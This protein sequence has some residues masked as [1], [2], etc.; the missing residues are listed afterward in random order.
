MKHH[1]RAA[2]HP[3]SA[4]LSI[5]GAGL[6]ARNIELHVFLIDPFV[7]VHAILLRI[8]IHGVVPPVEQGIG[9]RPVDRIAVAA[10]GII[11]DQPA[12]DVIDFPS[13]I[14]RIQH[15]EEPSLVIVVFI[16]PCHEVR[17]S[18]KDL[19]RPPT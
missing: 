7:P 9:L 5:E 10:A 17:F 13:T 12:S 3:N 15:Q 6:V 11:L 14:E 2:A 1:P 18:R 16:N 8:V 19:L 4:G